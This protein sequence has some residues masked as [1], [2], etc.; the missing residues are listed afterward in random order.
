MPVDKVAESQTLLDIANREGSLNHEDVFRTKLEKFQNRFREHR[1]SVIDISTDAEKQFHEDIEVINALGSLTADR[2]V[3]RLCLAVSR[4]LQFL[5]RR[6]E[7]G[8]N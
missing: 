6:G 4:A 8:E 7:Q 5:A 1:P 3:K 2:E